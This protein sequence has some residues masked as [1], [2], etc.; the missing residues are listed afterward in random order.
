MTEITAIDH[1]RTFIL[2]TGGR[3]YISHGGFL[4]VMH[5]VCGG[6]ISI[7][8][9]RAPGKIPWMPPVKQCKCEVKHGE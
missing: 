6:C 3:F 4:F 9:H 8:M 5:N 7:V 2:R 1:P